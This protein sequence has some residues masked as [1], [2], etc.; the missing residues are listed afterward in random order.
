MRAL[1]CARVPSRAGVNPFEGCVPSVPE[2]E[3]LDF[4]SQRFRELERAGVAAAAN[5]AFVLVAGG[6]G[7][8]LG[9]SGIKVGRRRM[10][11]CPVCGG[12][13]WLGCLLL[14]CQPPCRTLAASRLPVCVWARAPRC[15][16]QVALPVESA[17]G[18]CFLELYVK[19]ILALGV[20]LAA[21][22]R[23]GLGL[24][25]LG[26]AGLGCAWLGLA[27]RG[28]AWRARAALLPGLVAP[29]SSCRQAARAAAGSGMGASPAPLQVRRMRCIFTIRAH[30]AC[31][32]PASPSPALQA[33]GGRALPLAI[34]TS[35]DTHTRTLALLEKHAYWGAAP[36]QVTLIKQ[37][38]VACLA[39]AAPL[40][41][42]PLLPPPLLPLLQLRCCR[43]HAVL[44]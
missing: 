20:R 6:L 17:S 26:W 21:G 36:G 29:P 12:P 5:A 27:G 2:G 23:R 25:G 19:H 39:G 35:D 41:P 4:G 42:P 18:Q 1:P 14:P 3:R 37:E 40:L 10:C 8:R 30:A 28:V 24:V 31:G 44:C 13:H 7:E 38:K 9:Y 32:R 34:M 16:P 22:G 33:K 43:Q 11:V 15:P